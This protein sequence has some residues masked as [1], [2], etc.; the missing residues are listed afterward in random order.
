MR[1]V[2]IASGVAAEI[3]DYAHGRVPRAL[4]ER[5]ILSLAEELF[6]EEGFAGASMDELARRAGIS[7]PIIYALV[8]SK[9]QLYRRCVERMSAE[10]SS[11][12]AAAASSETDPAEQLRAGVGAFFTFVAEHR[13]LWE[14]LAWEVTP[15]AAE[16]A[17]IR[18]RQ[19]ELVAGL[20]ASNARRVGVNAD[21]LRVEAVAHLL[22]GAIEALARWWGSH[23]ALSAEQLTDWAVDVIL[24]GL[25]RIIEEG[26]QVPAIGIQR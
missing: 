21:P 15:F 5:Q 24:P 13:R 14:A 9:E 7:K 3:A 10:L 11:R 12:L 6:A 18:R 22:N 25:E 1:A 23:E 2:D 16:A 4:R 19:T 20:L 8:G 26:R 17:D